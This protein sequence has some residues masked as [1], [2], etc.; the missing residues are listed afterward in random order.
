MLETPQVEADSLVSLGLC[1]TSSQAVT[2]RFVGFVDSKDREGH[3]SAGAGS[4]H[5]TL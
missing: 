4:K 2:E 1:N 3:V 5:L